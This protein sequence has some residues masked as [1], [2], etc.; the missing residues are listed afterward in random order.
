MKI[1]PSIKS[2]KW[3][4][5]LFYE[6]G[7]KIFWIFRTTF[8]IL[9]VVW[10]FKISLYCG[11]ERILNRC[12]IHWYVEMHITSMPRL[13]RVLVYYYCIYSIFLCLVLSLLHCFY[14]CLLI[15]KKAGGK[16]QV[17]SNIWQEYSS[18]F[19]LGLTVYDLSTWGMA[20]NDQARE[21]GLRGNS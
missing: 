7:K 2:E 3:L 21:N 5:D 8:K 12:I 9:L 13:L 19:C 17:N 1:F 18:L 14:F 11:N 6:D 4:K 20:G 16:N 15:T 10:L